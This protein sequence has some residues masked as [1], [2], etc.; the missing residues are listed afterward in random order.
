MAEYIHKGGSIFTWVTKKFARPIGF[1]RIRTSTGAF[2]SFSKSARGKSFS[3]F[4]KWRTKSTGN[5][6]KRMDYMN[7]RIAGKTQKI[8]GYS[9]KLAEARILSTSRMSHYANKINAK[10]NKI[11]ALT[12]IA[13]KTPKQAKQ[14]KLA[15]SSLK[16]L[17]NKQKAVGASFIR[18]T[19]K[20]KYKM[21]K[22]QANLT[23]KVSKYSARK[24]KYTALMERKIYKSQK[25]LDK[26]FTKTCKKLKKSGKSAIGCL[27]AFQTCKAKGHGLNLAAMTGC[28]NNES[29]TMGVPSGLDEKLITDTMTKQVNKHFIRRFKRGRHL[30]E[31]KRITSGKADKLQTS[32]GT[33]AETLKYGKTLG[34]AKGVSAVGALSKARTRQLTGHEIVPGN[35]GIKD[36]SS[37]STGQAILK[38]DKL[39]KLSSSRASQTAL[40][41]EIAQLKSTRANPAQIADAEHRLSMSQHGSF[42]GFASTQMEQYA[43]KKA[44]K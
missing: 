21:S 3:P 23:K 7:K 19:T 8:E 24:Q 27:E 32:I 9:A 16:G 13:K 15:Q 34:E 11:T 41:S 35:L 25:R 36:F 1:K 31:I 26:G 30:R 4:A 43:K 28:V 33:T 18:K 20:I 10:Q 14:L 12:G 38:G 17:E 6:T 37:P 40:R 29:A 39:E 44:I 42:D 2:K 5:L 22:A